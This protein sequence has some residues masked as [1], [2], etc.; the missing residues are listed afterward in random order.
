MKMT[1]ATTERSLFYLDFL[2]YLKKPCV[3]DFSINYQS[4]NSFKKL[5]QKQFGFQQGHSPEH[6]LMQLINQIN[7]ALDN[8]YLL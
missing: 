2:K 8:D 4:T 7:Q 1:L 6:T 3:E 5:Y